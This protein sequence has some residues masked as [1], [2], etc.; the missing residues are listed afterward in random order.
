MR[1]WELLAGALIQQGVLRKLRLPAIAP[2]GMLLLSF[3]LNNDPPVVS[4]LLAVVAT[5]LLLPA[6]EE[7][8]AVKRM[9]MLPAL[10]H[11]GEISYSLYLWHWSVICLARWTIG[12][13][14]WRLP[15][16]LL[17]MIGCA[18]PRTAG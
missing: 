8:S 3:W 12:L 15:L 5:A 14:G 10:R 6:L 16:L 11:L 18:R 7:P 13:E 4:T 1:L 9:L 17:L 2:M